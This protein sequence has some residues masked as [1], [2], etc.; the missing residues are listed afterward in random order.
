MEYF[1][2]FWAIGHFLHFSLSEISLEVF[3]LF[4]FSERVLLLPF[5]GPKSIYSLSPFSSFCKAF[6]ITLL[7]LHGEQGLKD[8]PWNMHYTPLSKDGWFCV[9]FSLSF[10]LLF[11]FPLNTWGE[12]GKLVFSLVLASVNILQRRAEHSTRPYPRERMLYEHNHDIILSLHS[13][14]LVDIYTSHQRKVSN[15]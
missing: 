6:C 10:C 8:I 13:L 11:L 3:S 14:F 9:F 12:W 5:S 1:L 7:G 2:H 15:N 4:S